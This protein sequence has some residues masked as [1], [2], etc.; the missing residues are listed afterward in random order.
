MVQRTQ[1][2]A[3]LNGASNVF[4]EVRDFVSDGTGKSEYSMDYVMLYNILHIEFPEPLLLEAYRVLKSNG[5]LSIIHWNYDPKTPRGPSMSIRPRP[6]QCRDWA[7]L[8]GF[9]FVRNERLECCNWHWGMLLR[10][11]ASIEF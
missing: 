10:K 4:A 1:E 2:L 9:E 3:Q 8:V 5:L 7:E 6:E 11:P